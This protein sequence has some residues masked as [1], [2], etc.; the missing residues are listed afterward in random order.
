MVRVEAFVND[1]WRAIYIRDMPTRATFYE[2]RFDV[3][4][5]LLADLAVNGIDDVLFRTTIVCDDP[6]GEDITVVQTMA[7]VTGVAN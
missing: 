3:K 6:F 2:R 5:L 4:R 7:E 1:T